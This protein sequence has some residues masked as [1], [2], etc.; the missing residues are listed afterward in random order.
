MSSSTSS[1]TTHTKEL[2]E[3]G[4]TETSSMREQRRAAHREAQ[5]RYRQ[6]TGKLELWEKQQYKTATFK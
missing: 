2:G 3:A 1:S 5:R 4:E 6:G